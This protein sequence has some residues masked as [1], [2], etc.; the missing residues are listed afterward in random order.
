MAGIA[1]NPGTALEEIFSV[2]DVA[3]FI[4]LMSV[5]PGWSG[6]KFI[7]SALER[8]EKLKA[9]ILRRGLSTLIEVDGGI[10]HDTAPQVT[11]RGADI[12][13]AGNAFFGA[14]DR[15]AALNA[16]IS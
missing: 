11:A 4:V 5:N 2:L 6:Q 14:N 9:E 12:M 15:A 16:L 3:D 7:P 13:V 1:I 10:N 8:L